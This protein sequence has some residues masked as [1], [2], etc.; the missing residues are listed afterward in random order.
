MMESYVFQ[1]LNRKQLDTLIQWAEAEGWNPGPY[2]AEAYW[3][4]DP[5]GFYGY[6]DQN[7]LIAGGSI[8]SYDA[9]FGFMGFFI[10]KE[11]YRGKG[12]GRQLWFQRRNQLL[13]RL[14]KGSA[15]G[16]DGVIAMQS[17]YEKG[18]FRIAFR[19]ERHETIGRKTIF[20]KK[21]TPI[22]KK[23]IDQI[24]SYDFTCIAYPRASFLKKWLQM[25]ESF[26]FKYTG[27][28]NIKGYVHLRK[29]NKGYK[30]GPLFADDEHI[31]KDLFNACLNAVPCEQIN[32]DIPTT[33]KAAL[34]LSKAYNTSI[35]FECAR[36]YYGNPPAMQIHKIYGITSFE[37]G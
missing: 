1:K 14:V 34:A 36:M 9:F 5:E 29:A 2:D 30:I 16:M 28:K 15:I 37:L 6:F 21:V 8:V 3:A 4:A 25:P 23:E 33:N 12:I 11:G 31:A 20:S 32:I 18:G 26:S 10:V 13:S 22:E 24:L 27:N 19:D 7:E 35:I 17:F